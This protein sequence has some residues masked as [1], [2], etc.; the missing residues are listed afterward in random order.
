MSLIEVS[1]TTPPKTLEG[2]PLDADC[3]H[4]QLALP[5]QHFMDKHPLKSREDLVREACEML[6]ELIASCG[7]WS[8]VVTYQ[9]TVMDYLPQI[10]RA[11]WEWFEQY[12]RNKV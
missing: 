9:D 4:C 7:A 12:Q 10:I 5:V 3:L 2:E 1:N 11:K 8:V 6:A